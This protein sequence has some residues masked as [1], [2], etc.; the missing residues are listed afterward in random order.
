MINLPLVRGAV[1][2]WRLDRSGV[3]V[4]ARVVAEAVTSPRDDPAYF[5][6]YR[7]DPRTDP[8]QRGWTSR[9]DRPTYERGLAE[10]E[11]E[12]RVLPGN[13]S[14]HRAAGEVT[15]RL[16]LVLTVVADVVLLG[17]VVLVRRFRG[18]LRAQL[19]GVA[20]DDVQPGGGGALLERVEGDCY[21]VRGRVAAIED[22]EIVLDLVERTV[23]VHLDG[24][25]NPV[26]PDDSAE[27][28]ARLIG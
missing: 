22:D 17:V 20:V 15:S 25:H 12:V 9:V 8:E 5:L 21:L 14:A 24:H 6:Q 4:R 7:F 10:R 18:L 27:V 13:P 3:D 11:I 2:D 23:R 28:R 16:G 19:H 26:A 1:T